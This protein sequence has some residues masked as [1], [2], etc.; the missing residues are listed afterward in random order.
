MPLPFETNEGFGSDATLGLIVLQADESLEAEFRDALASS[1]NMGAIA[2]Y[3]SRIP[4]RPTV[5]SET[6]ALMKRDIPD[7]AQLLCGQGQDKFSAIAFCCTS[8]AT[9][10]GQ[11]NVAASIRMHHPHA[12]CTDPMSAVVAACRHLHIK[13]LGV[14]TPYVAE[15]SDKIRTLLGKEGI[16]VVSFGSFEQSDESTVAHITEASTMA[17][18][19]TVATQAKSAG[20]KCDAVFAS[21]TNLRTFGILQAA[22]AKIGMPVISSNQA[23]LWHLLRLSES[24]QNLCG[25]GKL[26][27]SVTG[28]SL[29]TRKTVT[30]SPLTAPHLLTAPLSADPTRLRLRSSI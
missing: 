26:L 23:L 5:T 1:S 29:S 6:L 2:C 8:A 11:E 25:Y 12:A 17:A 30:R 15:V 14:L 3:H 9:V 20:R 28:P 13:R 27:E 22:E 19:E 21:C 7:A 10:I 18:I 24:T 16:E 4:S